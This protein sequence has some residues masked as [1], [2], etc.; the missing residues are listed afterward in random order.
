MCNNTQTK[1]HA[2]KNNWTQVR[3]I[4]LKCTSDRTWTKRICKSDFHWSVLTTN[5]VHL[6]AWKWLMEID[7]CRHYFHAS[8]QLSLVS[9]T[10]VCLVLTKMDSSESGQ[11]PLSHARINRYLMEVYTLK[12]RMREWVSEAMCQWK[13]V[14]KVKKKKRRRA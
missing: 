9:F 14:C 2:R 6:G 13:E 5:S 7:N 12:E 10:V 8:V 4:Y 11:F 1:M 3:R